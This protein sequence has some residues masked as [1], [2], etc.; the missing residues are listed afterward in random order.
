M[1]KHCQKD[2]LTQFTNAQ[3][4][5]YIQWAITHALSHPDPAELTPALI[6]KRF[7]SL[8]FAAIQSSVITITNA[9]LDIAASPSC[10]SYLDT[11]RD[12]VLAETSPPSPSSSSPAAATKC[13]PSSSASP[14]GKAALARLVHVDSALRE[15]MR[16]NGFVAR[17]IMKTVLAPAGVTLPGAGGAHVP[18]GTKVGIQAYSVHRDGRFYSAP[19]TYD[20]FR[21]VSREA[22][23]AGAGGGGGG[24]GKRSKPGGLAVPESSRRASA[25]AS[26][27]DTESAGSSVVARK[28]SG[29]SSVAEEKGDRPLALVTTSPTFLAFSHGPN[30]W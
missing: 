25:G 27:S 12:E 8:C 3:Q 2:T 1:A 7:A 23:G 26:G 11:M 28:V 30:A 14:W 19:E 16:L 18:A 21:F 15:S 6:T 10:A 29:G 9:V 17:G 22:G 5:D 13:G 20:A 4:D 24:G